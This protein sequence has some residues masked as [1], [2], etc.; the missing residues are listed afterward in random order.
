MSGDCALSETQETSD[1]TLPSV[2]FAD[3]NNPRTIAV[4][5]T[6]PFSRVLDVGCGRG[7]VGRAL[8]ERGCSV[9]AIEMDEELAR[10]AGQWCERVLTADVE[11]LDLQ[12]AL[13]GQLFDVVLLLDVLE[14]LRDP[15]RQLRLLLPYLAPGG[16]LVISVPNVSHA[17]V[18]LQLMSGRFTRTDHG[19]LDRT[20][21]QFFERE[22]LRAVMADAGVRV[23]DELR[24][25]RSLTETEIPIREEAFPS[26]AVVLA[27]RGID[28]MTYQFVLIAVPAEGHPGTQAR[29]LAGVL[30]ERLLE[31][32][33]HYRSLEK[34]ALTMRADL[35]RKNDADGP[36]ASM[37]GGSRAADVMNAVDA[38]HERTA[39]GLADLQQSIER[40]LHE[41]L[42]A[43]GTICATLKALES[44][45]EQGQDATAKQILEKLRDSERAEESLRETVKTAVERSQQVAIDALRLQ[46]ELSDCIKELDRQRQRARILEL[47]LDAKET[48]LTALREE[49]QHGA[50]LMAEL[51]VQL[52]DRDPQSE[53]VR[54]LSERV[55]A[56]QS[57]LVRTEIV[58]ATAEAAHSRARDEIRGYHATLG[59]P[60]YRA[61]DS[62]NRFLS[63]TGP[64]HRVLKAIASRLPNGH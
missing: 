29:S 62:L 22:G 2:D 18:R 47:D 63:V 3:V 57:L 5:A 38:V 9:W 42:D 48:Y 36:G 23:I 6:P 40:R 31:L 13:G 51:R 11:M 14:H 26:E 61:A 44:R 16:R 46:R 34:W 7:H 53:P 8:R 59:L 55:D 37:D 50:T 54:T 27:T 19:L 35:E 41:S 64:L 32:E 30:N 60:R 58:A 25:V 24:V 12:P 45:L 4:L 17:A 33:T 20:H 43:S 56:L 21:L 49:V 15:V 28:A 10:A 1:I 52:G 39:R